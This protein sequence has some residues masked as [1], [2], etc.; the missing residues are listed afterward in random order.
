MQAS[1]SSALPLLLA[2]LFFSCNPSAT[3]N[4]SAAPAN[5]QPA[6][7]AL[8]N[9]HAHNDYEHEPPL[10]DALSHGFA[11]VEV[12]I[13]LAGNE[14]YVG[15]EPKELEKERT[16]E[17]LYLEPLRQIIAQNGG[18]VYANLSPLVLLIDIKTDADN[19]YKALR[20]VLEK[21][22]A[23][24]TTFEQDAEKSGP[25]LVIVSGRR[26][27]V[28][29]QAERKRYAAY[30][31]RL[32][33]LRAPAGS[34]FIPLI[35]DDWS[36]NFSWRGEGEMPAEEKEK[37]QEMT[38]AAHQRGQRIRFWATPDEAESAR[39][40]VWRE[41]LANGVDLIGTDDLAALQKF[42]SSN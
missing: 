7:A 39:E 11:S 24:L 36:K 26:P 22:E 28:F 33:D 16:L 42:L 32:E 9:A 23:M 15:H 17:F 3:K 35:S 8:P 19:T 27:R 30:D 31:G 34:E 14:L 4:F 18:K 37:L 13:Y 41:L 6:A 25:V 38:S 10:Y 21:H 40:A 12:D 5:W 29:M 20:R 1:H 2:A